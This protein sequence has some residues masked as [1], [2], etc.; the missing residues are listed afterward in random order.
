ML[1]EEMEQRIKDRIKGYNLTNKEKL[2]MFDEI[3]WY[4]ELYG[5]TLANMSDAKDFWQ[6]LRYGSKNSN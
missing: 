6:V 2:A 4:C 3:Q 1:T 5:V